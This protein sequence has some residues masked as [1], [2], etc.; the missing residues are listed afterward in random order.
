[1]QSTAACG[2][3][4]TWFNW[5]EEM[6]RNNSSSRK[7]ERRAKALTHLEKD[8]KHYGDSGNATQKWKDRVLYEIQTL[9]RRVTGPV[10]GQVNSSG[11]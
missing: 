5:S 11:S 9:R 2:D 1:V 10:Y 4:E 7:K 8:L 3:G 6:S